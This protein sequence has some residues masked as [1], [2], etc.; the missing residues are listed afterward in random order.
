MSDVIIQIVFASGNTHYTI[1]SRAFLKKIKRVAALI[2]SVCVFVESGGGGEDTGAFC[3][4][5]ARRAARAQKRRSCDAT[6]GN[7]HKNLV[8]AQ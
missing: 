7:L 4:G 6:R 5:A 1:S 8:P 2:L 3:R